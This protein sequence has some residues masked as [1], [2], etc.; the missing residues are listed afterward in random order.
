MLQVSIPVH[1]LSRAALLSHYG[2]EPIA[3]DNNH[4][5]LFQ[6][7]AGHALRHSARCYPHLSTEITFALTDELAIHISRHAA[8]IGARLYN[9]H[10]QQICLYALA[11]YRA[12]GS[13]SIRAA[14]AEWLTIYEVDED[15]YSVDTGYKLFQRYYWEL[16]KK[17]PRFS[18]QIRRK[19]GDVLPN[20]KAPRAILAQ[21]VRPGV[22]TDTEAVPELAAARF[23]AS[24]AE[25][26]RRL[27]HRLPMQVRTYM[28]Y[29]CAELT[30]REV[31]LKLGLKK[32]T[33]HYHLHA[34]RRRSA[35][36][37]TFSKILTESTA[38]PQP[39]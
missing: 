36:N 38:L 13:G 21:P 2:P 37:P 9:W 4:D 31:A 14:I 8:E 5:I 33:V 12:R 3:I 32:S 1:P 39:A 24:A 10:K 28:Y 30:E 15:Q 7:L 20:K 35:V 22:L 23:L 27:P 25:V 18:G 34:I 29:S 16:S 6:H 11:H 19:P 17:N 26:F